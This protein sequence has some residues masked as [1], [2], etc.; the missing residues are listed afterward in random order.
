MCPYSF[1]IASICCFGRTPTALAATRP[2]F[3]S[4][5]VG[6]LITP[7]S[8]ASSG[9][10]SMLTLT[11]LRSARCSPGY[12]VDDGG[13]HP[14]RAAPRRP[15]IDQDRQVGRQNLFG[16]GAFTDRKNRHGRFPFLV[17]FCYQ[18]TPAVLSC[19]VTRSPIS[20][21][22]RR[23]GRRAVPARSA[24]TAPRE[25]RTSPRSENT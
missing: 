7:N 12:L 16:E 6:M 1:S 14:A 4:T 9:S 17:G 18:Y 25:S 8:F 13:E 15:E 22:C 20:A 10:S 5:S 24:L 19:N 3:I 23:R 21:G 2:F 11:T